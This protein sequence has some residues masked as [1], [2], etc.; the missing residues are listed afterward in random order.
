MANLEQ[1]LT[2]IT[3]N[4]SS[5]GREN[6]LIWFLEYHKSFGTKII[7]GTSDL[8]IKENVS[9]KFTIVRCS[10]TEPIHHKLIRLSKKVETPYLI[11][12]ADDDF[13]TENMLQKSCS[14]LDKNEN[15]VACDGLT[16]FFRETNL[17]RTNLSY[18]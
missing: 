6:T 4:L 7:V 18:S 1:K 3:T 16:I 17:L 2:I 15:V 11:W 13:T 8:K 12:V 9:D 5:V 14:I 10:D